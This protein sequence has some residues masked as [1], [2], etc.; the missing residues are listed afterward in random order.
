VGFRKP[1]GWWVGGC[2]GGWVW[3]LGGRWVGGAHHETSERIRHGNPEAL[4]GTQVA[5]PKQSFGSP[6]ALYQ[7]VFGGYFPEVPLR[8]SRVKY[9]IFFHL[10]VCK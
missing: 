6:I 9:P 4:G 3:W 2:V 5:M 8:S 1:W 10:N 7:G